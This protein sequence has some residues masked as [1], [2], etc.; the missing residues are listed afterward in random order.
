MDNN[1]LLTINEVLREE[2]RFMFAKA[3]ARNTL[4]LQTPFDTDSTN[5]LRYDTEIR[6]R[7]SKIHIHVTKIKANS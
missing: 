6:L 7:L 2:F 4:V 5:D 1:I 3:T